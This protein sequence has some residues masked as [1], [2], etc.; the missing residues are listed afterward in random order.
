M[1]LEISRT[2]TQFFFISFPDFV[3]PIHENSVLCCCPRFAPNCFRCSSFA[4]VFLVCKKCAFVVFVE[5]SFTP[6]RFRCPL[7]TSLLFRLSRSVHFFFLYLSW[8]VEELSGFYGFFFCSLESNFAFV[9][10][11]GFCLFLLK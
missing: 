9:C 8:E 10:S 1:L 2:K 11:W 4:F 6:N 3:F 5:P 7:V